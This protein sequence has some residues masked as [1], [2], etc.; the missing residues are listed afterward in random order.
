MSKLRP[1]LFATL[2]FASG[3][4]AVRL[5]ALAQTPEISAQPAAAADAHQVIIPLV[6]YDKKGAILT[7][8]TK[9]SFSLKVDGHEQPIVSFDRDSNL[10]LTL[11]LLFDVTYSQRDALDDERTASIAFLNNIL[12]DR[13]RAFV[14]QFAR[15]TDLLQDITPSRPKLQA[16]LKQIEAAPAPPTDT[17]V[18][19]V[20]PSDGSGNGRDSNAPHPRRVSNTLYDAVFLSSDELLHKQTGR[21]V[22]VV[23][24]DGV[25]SGS[26]ESLASA[27]EAAQ[28][29]DTVV[30]VIYNKGRESASP[31]QNQGRQGGGFPGGGGRSGGS[32][33]PGSGGGYPGGGGHGQNRQPENLPSN[34]DGKK[35]LQRV[36]EETGGRLFEVSRKQS[37]SDIFG[38]I[39][40]ELRAE[41][42]LVYTP[43]KANSSDGYHRI[44]LT[45]AKANPKDFYLQFRDG[46]YS[47]E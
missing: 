12:A 8:F 19:P 41:F 27:I 43:D 36:A 32:G 3:L 45:L 7:N 24:S 44:D 34:V 15:Q 40:D 16:A 35:I 17:S 10:P 2:F 21:K 33:Y 46:Y 30:Y 25:D 29:A 28:R 39:S 38:E 1:I 22:L 20:T 5:P 18:T 42:R 23:L 9:D 13:D 4:F 26:K 37:F 14:V 11:G 31:N 6:V 47:G